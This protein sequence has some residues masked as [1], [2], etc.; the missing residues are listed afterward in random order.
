MTF[1]TLPFSS[2]WKLSVTSFDR[3]KKSVFD[4]G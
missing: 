2:F 3:M 4:S 1:D